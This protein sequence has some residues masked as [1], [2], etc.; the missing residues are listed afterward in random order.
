MIQMCSSKHLRRKALSDAAMTL[1]KMLAVGRAM[2]MSEAQAAG[3]EKELQNLSVNRVND[4]KT[5]PW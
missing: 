5:Q 2:E 4:Q 3:I 1:N